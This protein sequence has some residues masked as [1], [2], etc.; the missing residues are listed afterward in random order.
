MNC[1]QKEAE[2]LAFD[3]ELLTQYATSNS[4]RIQARMFTPR[5]VLV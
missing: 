4:V 3:A 5:Y 1:L 2:L